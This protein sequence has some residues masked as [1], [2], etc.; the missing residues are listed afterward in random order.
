MIKTGDFRDDSRSDFD[1]SKKAEYVDKEGFGVADKA[2][3]GNLT[4]PIKFTRLDSDKFTTGEI[5]FI[6]NE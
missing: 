2:N 5:E 3:K 6:T 1:M 4:N